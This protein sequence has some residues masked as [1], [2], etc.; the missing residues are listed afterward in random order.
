MAKITRFFKDV[1]LTPAGLE[2]PNV[3]NSIKNI[4]TGT[5]DQIVVLQTIGAATSVDVELRY[6]QGNSARD[7]VVYLFTAGALPTF[8]DSHI[9]G[10]FSLVDRRLQGDLHLYLKPDAPC[11]VNIRIDMEIIN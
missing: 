10:P 1:S 6:E 7:K 5:I 11:T 4:H 2:I 9:N 8:V 3:I